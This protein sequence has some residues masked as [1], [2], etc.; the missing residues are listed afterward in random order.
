MELCQYPGY[1]YDYIYHQYMAMRLKEKFE[2]NKGVIRSRKSKM[3]IQYK[4]QEKKEQTDK[5]RSTKH[6]TESK[7]SSNTNPMKTGMNSVAAPEGLA[8]P[9]PQVTPAVLLLNDMNII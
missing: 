8:V 7:R 1:H 6:Y 9:V 4:G 3:S 2:D 5:Q